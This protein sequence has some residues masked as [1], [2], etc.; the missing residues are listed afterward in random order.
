MT[1]ADFVFSGTTLTRFGS[2]PCCELAGESSG[3]SSR[4]AAWNVRSQPGSAFRALSWSGG[5]VHSR[6]CAAAS[7][8]CPPRPS[9]RFRFR[10]S[11]TTGKAPGGV[12][13]ARVRSASPRRSRRRHARARRRAGRPTARERRV[14]SWS[15]CADP[16]TPFSWVVAR[17]EKHHQRLCRR[18]EVRGPRE[19]NRL[20]LNFDERFSTFHMRLLSATSRHCLLYTSPSPRDS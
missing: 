17:K 3:V 5:M 15:A 2:A 16:G 11:T 7:S 12:A 18:A 6:R 10:V 14:P 9:R 19:G 20:H 4:G 1:C 13:R 8:R